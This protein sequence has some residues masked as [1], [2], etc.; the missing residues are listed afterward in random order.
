MGATIRVAPLPAIQYMAPPQA[1]TRSHQ[2][3]G[4]WN[5]DRSMQCSAASA[6]KMRGN[7]TVPLQPPTICRT[8]SCAFPESSWGSAPWLIS[9]LTRLTRPWVISVLGRPAN[10]FVA[11]TGGPQLEKTSRSTVIVVERVKP[12][13]PIHKPRQDCCIACLSPTDPGGRLEWTSWDH[14]LDPKDSIIFG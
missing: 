5:T 6:N 1:T 3:S 4:Y 10:I 9:S 2:G 14:S 11:G 7:P 8:R 12:R 13:N